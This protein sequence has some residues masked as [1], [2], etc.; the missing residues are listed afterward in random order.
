MRSVEGRVLRRARFAAAF[1]AILASVE[2]V[3]AADPLADRLDAALAAGALRGG[4][5][6]ALVVELKRGAARYARRPDVALEP[7]SNLKILTALGVL[8]AFGPTHRF[9]TE[10]RS[11]APPNRGSDRP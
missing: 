6:A 4:R 7:A 5:I 10:V 1:L 2:G 9:V 3:A 11:A 8:S